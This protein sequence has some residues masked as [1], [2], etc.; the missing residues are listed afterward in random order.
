MRLT[1]LRPA[2][3]L[4]GNV[5]SAYVDASRTHADGAHEVELRW[6]SVREELRDQG[7]DEKVV[8]QV[9]ERLLQPTGYGGQVARAVI[10]AD[11]V[12]TDSTL[13]APVGSYGHHG[14]I[15]HLLPLAR[16]LSAE[17]SYALVQV[18]R[19]GADI[20]LADTVNPTETELQSQGEHEV[21]HKV[22]GGGLS[23][24]R[25]Q[26]RVEDSWDRNA[27]KVAHDLDRVVADTKPD[28]VLL[29]G[30]AYA[31]SVVHEYASGRLADRL[32]ELE[33]GSRAEGASLRR[34]GEDVE[35]A[36]GEWR[37]ARRREVLDR[38]FA[39]GD[40]QA[41]GV[42]DTVE[43]LRR[44]EVETLVLVDGALAERE[45][46]AGPAPLQI[47]HTADELRRLGADQAEMDR[48]DE[49]LLRALVGQDG[50]LELLYSPV[51]GLEEGVG[52]VLRFAT[53]PSP[54]S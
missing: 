37:S 30:D 3:D 4:Y 35:S 45:A 52:A 34:L 7:A 19:A 36:V 18:D 50:E 44:G 5:V 1:A 9:A 54:T 15:A 8:D 10:A 46:A 16:A 32:H 12:V 14:A 20:T 33:H 42:A 41:L 39:A 21:L 47:G 13:A 23:H 26:S 49:V 2:A 25:I 29:T 31:R 28:V 11:E 38:L 53:R 51:D 17:V 27:E 6:R 40:R 24:R 48:A 22:P 43:A